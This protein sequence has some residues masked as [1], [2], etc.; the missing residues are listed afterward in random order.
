MIKLDKINK[1]REDTGAGVMDC[2]KALE[3]SK[4]EIKKAKEWLAEKREKIVAKKADRETSEGLIEA[5]VHKNG[6]VGAMIKISCETD[7]VARNE[8]FQ[9]LAKEIAMQVA[10]MEPE[11]VDELLKQKYIRNPEKTIK[12][13]VEEAIA[14]IGENIQIEKISRMKI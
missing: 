10:A 12:Q 13:I 4:G 6:R 3:A 8:E 1:L 2:K 14:K 5:Y 7:F 11:N 9:K